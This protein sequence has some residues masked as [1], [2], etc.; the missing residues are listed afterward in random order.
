MA[1][2]TSSPGNRPGTAVADLARSGA[3]A[4]QWRLDPGAS[5]VEFRVKHLWGAVT[6]RGRFERISG[7][8][9]VSPGGTVTGKLVIDA[10]SLKTSN[11]RRDTH[12]RS[13]DFFDVERHPEVVVTVTAAELAGTRLAAAGMLTA[14]GV[15][16][17]VTFTADITEASAQAVT[18][19]ASLTVDRTRFGMTWSPLGMAARLATGTVSARFARAAT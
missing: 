3:L 6:V 11:K 7:E 8:G 14:A 18:L 2:N 16:E 12:L 4:G 5:R 13:A 1:T 17:P 9:T 10:A 19:R 15:R